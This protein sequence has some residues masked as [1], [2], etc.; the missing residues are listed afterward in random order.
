MLTAFA[1]LTWADGAE[2]QT[3]GHTAGPL[4][5]S[6]VRP[7]ERLQLGPLSLPLA[8]NTYTGGP[9]DWPARLVWLLTGS[10][11]A[12]AATHVALGGLLLVLVHRFLRIHGSD[13]AAAVAAL[14]LAT[15]WHFLF[16]KKVLGGTEVLLQA[17][18]L[19]CLWALWSRRWAGG[20]HGVTAL[21]VGIGLGLLAKSTFGISLVALGGA[22]LLTRWDRPSIRPPLPGD[23]WKPA[24]AVVALTSP[25]W[26]GALHRALAP[27]LVPV[28]S[29]D[30]GDLQWRRVWTALT[31][32]KTPVREG[33]GNGWLWFADPLGFLGVAYGVEA[34]GPSGLRLAGWGFVAGGAALAWRDRHPTPRQAL[35]RF[36]TVFLALQVG[37]LLAIA[38]D[39]HHLAQAAPTAAVVAG[40]A[41]DSLAGTVT[42]PRGFPRARLAGLLAVPWLVSGAL[43]LKRTDAVVEQ[44][45]VP[46]FTESGQR[47]L[48]ELVRRNGVARLVAADYELY[49]VLELRAPEVHVEHGWSAF[50]H[51][52]GDA[53]PPLLAHAA[54]DH[55]LV[56]EAS[57]PMIYNLRASPRRL[58]EAAGEAG[59][60]LTEVDRLPGGEAV[61][62]AVS[63]GP[64]PG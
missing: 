17:A 54:G 10:L 26:V 31:L 9:P 44:V 29:H 28:P 12:V 59:V 47:A 45:P 16:Y 39:L 51:L 6:V 5:A 50:A 18:G 46:T 58:Q 2:A 53:A 13:V 40:L 30:F 37:L 1:P 43:T 42:P 60:V 56:L 41:L 24:L 23:L 25:L 15:D 48:V 32:G 61:L 52:R 3:A 22:A 14:V 62:Y 63:A 7:L 34:G 20:R 21:G 38:R 33:L 36:T 57:A 4:V 19:L 8:I 49:G 27:E 11:G 55:L 35:L 64:E